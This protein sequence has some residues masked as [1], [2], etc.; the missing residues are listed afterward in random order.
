MEGMATFSGALKVQAKPGLRWSGLKACVRLVA[1]ALVGLKVARQFLSAVGSV[2]GEAGRGHC[3]W[4]RGRA[5]V[6]RGRK[7]T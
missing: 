1:W 3:S 7:S 5:V 6:M 4:K 2:G